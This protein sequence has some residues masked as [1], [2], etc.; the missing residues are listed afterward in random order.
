MN[1]GPVKAG[2]SFKKR[3]GGGK[4]G[5]E[6]GDI[7]Q[8]SQ[9]N[10][11]GKTKVEPDR[12]IKRERERSR[13][14]KVP[15]FRNGCPTPRDVAEWCKGAKEKPGEPNDKETK[16][17]REGAKRWKTGRVQKGK[18]KRKAGDVERISTIRERGR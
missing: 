2:S 4:K 6:P 18:K 16:N 14:G 10:P 17:G 13:K 5:K 8:R 3:Q 7:S 11:K 9:L 15:P 1:E 12:K